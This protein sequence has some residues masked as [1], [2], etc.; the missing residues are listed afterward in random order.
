M[1][2]YTVVLS[3]GDFQ[4]SYIP[5]LILS[6]ESEDDFGAEEVALDLRELFLESSIVAKN[7]CCDIAYN[8]EGYNFCPE[9]GHELKTLDDDSEKWSW[10][11]E[12]CSDI[13]SLTREE[14]SEEFQSA[15]KKYDYEI[16]ASIKPGIL[17]VLNNFL[18]YIESPEI[19][20]NFQKF[21]I[22]EALCV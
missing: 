18:E 21:V 16:A 10:V 12:C 2:Y 13:Y 17:I 15:L 22:E 5:K 1:K 6:F 9:C 14:V 7:G 8:E 19:E 20:Y 4:S 3:D 11:K